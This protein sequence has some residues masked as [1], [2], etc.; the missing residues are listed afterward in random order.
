MPG[1]V[2]VGSQWGDEG[3]GKIVDLLT[4]RVDIVARY[5]GGPNAGHTIEAGGRRFALHHVPSG[6]LRDGVVC[7]IGNGMVVH[8]ASL[9]QEIADLR[10]AGVRVE[11]NLRLSDRAHVILPYH[12]GCDI[13]REDGAAGAKIGTT[14]LGV[15]PAYES[16]AGRYGVRVADLGDAATLPAKIGRVAS[17]LRR[18]CADGLPREFDP[19]PERVAQEYLEHGRSLAPYLCDTSVLLNRRLDEG[20]VVL[21]EGAQGTLLDLDHGSYPFVTSSSSSAGGAC[22]GLGISPIR[23]EGVFG[24]LKAYSTRVGE[25]PFPTEQDNEAGQRI[26]DRGHEYGSTTGRPRRCGWFD[27]LVARYAVTLNQIEC[28]ALTLFDVLDDLEE[29]PV[30]VAYEHEG[31]RYEAMPADEAVLR[32][33]RPLYEVLPGWKSDTSDV[34]RFADLPP[35]AQRYVLRLEKIVGC[36]IGIVSVSPRREKTI[37]RPE[38]RIAR[39]L[40]ER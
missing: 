14:R 38:S 19:D 1:F 17:M 29:I 35:A 33:C 23:V 5:G 6:I 20:A 26:R 28:M 9:L 32:A 15:G 39:W 8:P 30:C 31:R 10:A 24:V 40:P 13:A 37:L 7:V 12:R 18:A 34:T 25:G 2:V 36:E 3:K 21:C 16:K 27:A 22:T 4:E 11:D